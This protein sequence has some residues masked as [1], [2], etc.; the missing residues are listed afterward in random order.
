M[1]ALVTCLVTAP[2]VFGK[3]QLDVCLRFRR[4]TTVYVDILS[5][6]DSDPRTVMCLS[7]HVDRTL[8]NQSSLWAG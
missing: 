4:N 3:S 1:T 6:L 5:V 7:R 2:R 8:R